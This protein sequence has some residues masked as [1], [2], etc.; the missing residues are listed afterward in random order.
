MDIL[1]YK[2]LSCFLS[3]VAEQDS[4]IALPSHFAAELVFSGAMENYMKETSSQLQFESPESRFSSSW[5]LP[6]MGPHPID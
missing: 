6:Q 3:V 2:S 1:P 5:C 4:L